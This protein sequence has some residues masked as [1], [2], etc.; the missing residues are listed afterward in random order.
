[1]SLGTWGLELCQGDLEPPASPGC[2]CPGA[3]PQPAHLETLEEG[4][5]SPSPPCKGTGL[6]L[7]FEAERSFSPP[8]PHLLDPELPGQSRRPYPETTTPMAPVPVHS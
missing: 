1:M 4:R 6:M 3:T 5:A 2:P 7:S 8:P